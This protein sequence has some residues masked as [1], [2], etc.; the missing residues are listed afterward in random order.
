MHGGAFEAWGDFA[1][2]QWSVEDICEDGGQLVSTG[3]QTSWC[4]TVWAWC[5][6][7]FLLLE[8]LAH[9]VFADL[10][11][12]C[13]G[14]GGCWRCFV[15]VWR[16]VQGGCGVF[17]QTCSRTRSDHLPVVDSPQCWRMVSCS[18]WS[19]SDLSTLMLSHWNRIVSL[20]FQNKKYF[21]Y[22]IG[23]LMNSAKCNNE[24]YGSFLLQTQRPLHT[25]YSL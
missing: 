8:D 17:F 16:G 25:W 20:F 9:L 18:W 1:Q 10:N 23:Y 11:C 7:P 15:V 22:F 12:T 13:G 24:V 3:F 14:E 6:F 19:L 4:D 21:Y 2:F 5:F